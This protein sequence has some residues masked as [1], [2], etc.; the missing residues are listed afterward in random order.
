MAELPRY[1][2]LG[3]SIPSM[4]S[5]DYISA[6]KTKAGVFDTVSNAL[7]KMSEFAFE[8]QKARVELEG[9]AYGAANAPTKEQI[10]TAKKPISEMMQ[11]DPTTVFGVAAKAAAAE[12]IEG[13]FLVRAGS[14]LTQLRLDAKENNT[15]IEAFQGQVQNLIDG[16]SSILQGIS[17]E[18]ANK[19]SATLATKGNSAIISHNDDLIAAQEQQDDAAAAVGIDNILNVTLPE[20]FEVGVEKDASG[21]EITIDDKL[22]VLRDELVAVAKTSTNSDTLIAS[23][24]KEF[25]EAVSNAKKS[26]VLSWVSEN[27]LGHA[28]QLRE[29][30]VQDQNIANILGSL[31]EEERQDII[32][33]GLKVGREQMSFDVSVETQK[34]KDR[35]ARSSRLT[36]EIFKGRVS[37]MA[38]DE[39]RNK[40]KEL[41]TLDPEKYIQVATAIRTEGGIDDASVVGYLRFL[42]SQKQLTEEEIL[43]AA[44]DRN[45]S[46]STLD[47]FFNALEKQRDDN[48]QQA[49]DI[50]RVH[51]RIGLP[52]KSTF[53]IGGEEAKKQRKSEQ[54]FGQI[55][56]ELDEARRENPNLNSI[57][58][59]KNR[60]KELDTAPDDKEI[61]KARID[62][63]ALAKTL[64]L[65]EEADP[66]DVQIELMDKRPDLLDTYKNA[67]EILESQ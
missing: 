65:P 53:V 24:T 57:Q 7:D 47:T 39:V 56:I 33:E 9:A 42:Q 5:V 43:N 21:N 61:K 25:D 46:L 58:W 36:V 10:E 54:L 2:P 59:M 1:R 18:A 55:T 34:E 15:D 60:V 23:K 51:P 31:T 41:E 11:I 48:Y 32:I 4:P 27:R 20:I 3:V 12:Q 38:L 16:Y 40:L 26:V 37:G 63:G 17:P 30:K 6:A 8:K 28:R 44:M 14:E 66:V 45:I 49:L 67:F 62:I 35:A 50:A 13:R 19:F 22:A 52:D 64:G 29:N